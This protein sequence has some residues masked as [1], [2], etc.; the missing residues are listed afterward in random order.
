M[1][2]M[3]A[4]ATDT[5]VIAES[6]HTGDIDQLRRAVFLA[7]IAWP[8]FA[9]LDW[10]VV[11]FVE[12]GPLWW[13]L[14]LRLIGMVILVAILGVLKA[15]RRPSRGTALALDT[16]G[17]SA[18]VALVAIQSLRVGGIDSPLALGAITILVARSTLMI[19]HWKRSMVA[20]G[21]A[22]LAFPLT[23]LFCAALSDTVR[24]ELSRGPDLAGFILNTLFLLS[25]AALAIAGGHLGWRVRRRLLENTSLGRY[26]LLEK[27][28]RGGMGDVWRAH[29]RMLRRDVALKILRVGKDIDERAIKRFEREGPARPPS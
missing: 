27:V 18:L 28:G 5:L 2:S 12:P 1:G 14:A 26:D 11:A 8:S 10:Y 6:E 20:L 3:S 4:T 15:Q 16:I 25:A 29:D 23:I 13:F 22:A 19:R 21:G 7:I 24:A 9:L 17:C